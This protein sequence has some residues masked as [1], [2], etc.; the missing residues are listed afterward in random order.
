MIYSKADRMISEIIYDKFIL[1]KFFI[2][3][4]LFITIWGEFLNNIRA[5]LKSTNS[6]FLNFIAVLCR[7]IIGSPLF[8]GIV[9][10]K[11]ILRI[12]ILH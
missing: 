1:S 2:N 8:F 3:D 12:C 5:V 4:I 7:T 6:L 11:R 10:G 9:H